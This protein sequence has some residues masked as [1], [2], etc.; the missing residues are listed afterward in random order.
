MHHCVSA[1]A[2]GWNSLCWPRARWDAAV[3]RTGKKIQRRRKK[4][5]YKKD[6]ETSS[7]QSGNII[8]KFV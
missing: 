2:A 8:M 4:K 7:S 5:Q 1:A 3:G 6:T